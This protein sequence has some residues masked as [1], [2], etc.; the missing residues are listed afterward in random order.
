MEL[1]PMLRA[2]AD[3][4]ERMQRGGVGLFYCSGHA[5]QVSGRNFLVPSDTIDLKH[6][7][8]RMDGAE[9]HLNIVILDA[10]RNNPFARKW[11]SLA[12][13]GALSKGLAPTPAPPGTFVAYATEPDSV[14]SDGDPGGNGTYTAEL[15]R[16]LSQ[17]GLRIEDVFKRT[18]EGVLRRTNRSQRPWVATNFTGDFYFTASRRAP[19]TPAP[20]VAARPPAPAEPPRL[21]GREEVRHERARW[22]RPQHGQ[23]RQDDDQV[24]ERLPGVH[25]PLATMSY[26]PRK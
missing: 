21:E 9:N 10:C 26:R 4:A 19:T 22:L 6:V 7:L 17:P 18:A 16:F 20:I 23:Q 25:Q 24:G 12:R 15:L 1:R 5:I 11:P 3:F 13:G 2:L 14:A 8:D